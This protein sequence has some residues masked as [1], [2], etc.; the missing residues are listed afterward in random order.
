MN[1]EAQQKSYT[2]NAETHGLLWTTGGFAVSESVETGT[3]GGC[4]ASP[5]HRVCV[6]ANVWTTHVSSEAPSTCSR[7]LATKTAESE[8][9][10]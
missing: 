10:E 6:Y 9:T 2:I 4:S 8:L 1:S 5:G 7:A 3:Y